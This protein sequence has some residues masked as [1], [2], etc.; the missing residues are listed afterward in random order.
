MKGRP[1][2]LPLSILSELILSLDILSEPILSEPILS[3]P[4][5]SDPI[6]SDPILSDPILSE[7]ILSELILSELILSDD[8]LSELIFSGAI[9]PPVPVSEEPQPAI[10][11]AT[12]ALTA[13]HAKPSEKR[14]MILSTSGGSWIKG[15]A[16]LATTHVQRRN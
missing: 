11:N 9:F 3:E 14:R 6:L 12:K 4:I 16:I 5:L 7:D 15:A 2:Y 13:T 10:P 1:A 8:I